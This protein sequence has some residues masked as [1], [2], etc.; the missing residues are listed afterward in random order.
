MNINSQLL[1]EVL[2]FL[3]TSEAVWR[4]VVDKVREQTGFASE[5]PPLQDVLKEIGPLPEEALFFGLA[6]DDLPV[7]L[8]MWDPTPG[9]ILVAA[10]SE[11]GKTDFLKNIARYVISTHASSE[12][13]YGV[14]TNRLHEWD[15]CAEYPHCVGIFSMVQESAADFIQALAIWVEMN[16]IS[17]QSVL[18]LIDGLADFVNF[19]NNMTENLQKIFLYGPAKK[20][21]PVVTINLEDFQNIDGWLRFFQTRV[22]GY[23]KHARTIHQSGHPNTGFEIL[24]KGIE[25]SLIE[26]S[27]W[28]K[29]RIPRI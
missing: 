1:D 18:L 16:K 15:G 21:W 19:N 10:D 12:I 9:P 14:I 3:S 4:P 5:L 20:V 7:L 24:C 28:I 13:Q 6:D 29:F 11:T 22:F 25:F 2:P 8:N 26:D 27:H 17:Q 23:T